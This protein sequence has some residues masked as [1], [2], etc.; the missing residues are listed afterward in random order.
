MNAVKF[1]RYNRAHDRRTCQKK[2]KRKKGCPTCERCGQPAD[3]SV[4]DDAVDAHSW[5]VHKEC[6]NGHITEYWV[7]G[8][9]WVG[10]R[11]STSPFSGTMMVGEFVN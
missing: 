6:K 3:L 2:L 11:H 1:V 9:R 4:R 8:R 5:V 10:I 7:D